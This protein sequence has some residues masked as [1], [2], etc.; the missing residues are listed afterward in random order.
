[1]LPGSVARINSPFQK[2]SDMTDNSDRPLTADE[3][4][5]V[6]AT[7]TRNQRKGSDADNEARLARW[8]FSDLP[9]VFSMRG[10]NGVIQE[11]LPCYECLSQIFEGRGMTGTT[12]SEGDIIVAEGVPN[13]QK[14]PLNRAAALKYIDWM[15]SLP[16]SQAPIDIGDMSEAS[17]MLARDPESQ[18][19]SQDDW[20]RA[21]I[22]LAARLKIKRQG[23]DALELPMIQHNF[24]P[25]PGNKAPPILGA[26]LSDMGARAPGFTNTPPAG[27][28][29]AGGAR[30]VSAA[31]AP[32]GGQ[33]GPR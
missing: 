7:A 22:S 10:E 8:G 20:Q 23:K 24:N 29:T 26:K 18:K 1:M 32:L 19:L 4:A 25:Q 6:Q 31:P 17:Q 9:V 16:T 12:Y 15:E 3:V 27:A 2:D 21:V 5:A 14:R 30:R 33:T 11:K 28:T 13:D